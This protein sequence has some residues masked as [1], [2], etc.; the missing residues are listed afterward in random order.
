MGGAN[1]SAHGFLL[2]GAGEVMVRGFFSA[3]LGYLV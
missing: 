3:L 2:Y 1:S